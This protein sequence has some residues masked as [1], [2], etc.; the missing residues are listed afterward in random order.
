MVGGDLCFQPC[1]KAN[2]IAFL[3]IN[4]FEGSGRWMNRAVYL[5]NSLYLFFVSHVL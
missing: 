3:S 1:R 5:M 4:N 2:I